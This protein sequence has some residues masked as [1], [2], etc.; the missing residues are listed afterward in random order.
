M[1]GLKRSVDFGK[2]PGNSTPMAIVFLGFRLGGELFFVL[3]LFSF[4]NVT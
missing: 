3:V 2:R 4:K 1:T